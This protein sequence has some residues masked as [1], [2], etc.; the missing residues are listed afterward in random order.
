MGKLLVSKGCHTP[1]DWSLP[2]ATHIRILPSGIVSDPWH[3]RRI[4]DL[5]PRH[6]APRTIPVSVGVGPRFGQVW[7]RWPPQEETLRVSFTL[8][9]PWGP[10]PFPHQPGTATP[11]A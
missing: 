5:T 10:C 8:A 6:L 11:R 1:T 7:G 3:R 4:E 9:K 2:S